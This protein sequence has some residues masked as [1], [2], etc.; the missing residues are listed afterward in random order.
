M[1]NIKSIIDERTAYEMPFLRRIRINSQLMD[2][3]DFISAKLLPYLFYT[4]TTDNKYRIIPVFLRKK[5][6]V[7]WLPLFYSLALFKTN[8][9]T[10]LNGLNFSNLKFPD[11]PVRILDDDNNVCQLKAV[12]FTSSEIILKSGSGKLKYYDFDEAPLLELYNNRVA[13]GKN[14]DS[15]FNRIKKYNSSVRIGKNPLELVQKM[16]S[17][18]F[19]LNN[20]FNGALFF[21]HNPG[22]L[23]SEEFKDLTIN[24][25][26]FLNSIPASRMSVENGLISFKRL[27]SN[28]STAG[29]QINQIKEFLVFSRFDN[30]N[31]YFVIKQERPWLNT[32][33]F[34][35]T[36]DQKEL[37]NVLNAIKDNYLKPLTEGKIKDIYLVFN[38][39]DLHSYNYILKSKLDNFPFFLNSEAKKHFLSSKAGMH[40]PEAKLVNIPDLSSDFKEAIRIARGLCKEVHIINLIDPLVKPLFELKK[41]FNSFYNPDSLEEYLYSVQASLNEIRNTWFTGKEYENIFNFLFAFLDK[42][43]ASRGNEKLYLITNTDIRLEE[44]TG[45]VS[46]NENQDDMDFLK[47][48]MHLEGIEFMNPRNIQNPLTELEKYANVFVL[49]STRELSNAI[50]ANSFK[51]NVVLILNK[52]EHD[53]YDKNKNCWLIRNLSSREKLYDILNLDYE[54][55]S[56]PEVISAKPETDETDQ[57]EFDLDSFIRDVMKEKEINQVYKNYD[58]TREID[59]IIL[60]FRDGTSVTVN[61]SKYFFIHKED[62]KILKECHVQARD[63]KVDDIIFLVMHDAEEFEK[64]IWQIAEEQPEIKKLLDQDMKWRKNIDSY[65]RE[66]KITKSS[67]RALLKENGFNIGSDQAIHTWVYGDVYEPRNM[68]TLIDVLCNLGILVESEKDE[69]LI[70]IRAVKK[71]KTRLPG[72]LQKMNIANMNDLIYTSDYSFPE[73][74]EKMYKFLDIKTI[75]YIIK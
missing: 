16:N 68:E 46:F 57:M 12:N 44:K 14:L 65:L 36:R 69:T 38:E 29:R 19:D 60:F 59:S 61:E 75:S 40:E 74:L 9:D 50:C 54:E 15:V 51:S 13:Y 37:E 25:I 33:I 10:F 45:I 63:L 31:E 70:S 56:N 67:F 52:T 58:R 23:K 28:R 30:F 24:E 6:D 49:N 1:M 66:N 18:E 17:H 2:D 62:P 73:L 35:F 53:Q 21:T 7:V 48:M 39:K 42:I 47:A 64:L 22:L 43:R 71:L 41:R 32:L 3:S 26:P 11:Q 55:G 27:G 5:E 72:E 20:K 8:A 34:D 4:N